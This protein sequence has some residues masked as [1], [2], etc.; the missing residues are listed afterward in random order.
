MAT[1][2]LTIDV[3]DEQKCQILQ[4]IATNQLDVTVREENVQ[5]SKQDSAAQ[6]SSAEGKFNTFYFEDCKQMC[7]ICRVDWFPS[8]VFDN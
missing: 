3:S 2:R 6:S 5:F 4:F 8:T 7:L 1:A